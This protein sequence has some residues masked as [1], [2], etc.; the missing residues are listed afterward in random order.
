[1][2]QVHW[3][4]AFARIDDLR[5]RLGDG[6]WRH[7]LAAIT[8]DDRDV[9]DALMRGPSTDDAIGPGGVGVGVGDRTTMSVCHPA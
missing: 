9:I 2:W 7:A 4:E 6:P 3:Q 1:M 8:A 5:T